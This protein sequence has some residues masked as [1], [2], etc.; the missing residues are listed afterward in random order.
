MTHKY[1]YVSAGKVCDAYT[2]IY[3]VMIGESLQ[4]RRDRDFLQSYAIQHGH[5]SQSTL[6]AKIKMNR[7]QGAWSC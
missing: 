6:C 3:S 2:C 5:Y 1:Y 7:P 4:G